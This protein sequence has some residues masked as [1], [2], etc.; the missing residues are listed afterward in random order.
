MS[1]ANVLAVSRAAKSI[2]LLGD[3]Q[4][5]EQPQKGSHPDGVGR[6]GA[7]STSS[8]APDDAAGRGIVPAGDVAAGAGICAFTSEVFYEGR[9]RRSPASS[10]SASSAPAR[11]TAP[12][13]G[14]CRWSTTAISNCVDRGSRR[15]RARWSRGC[16]R[17]ARSGSTRT[18]RARQLTA[19]RHPRRRALQRAGH[20]AG[21]AA[22]GR[23][24][25]RRH[26]GQVPGPGGAGRHL[27][28]GHVAARGRAA[29][30]GVP[31]QPQPAERGHVA[32]AVRGVHRGSP[33]SFEPE[34][35]TP[36]QMQLANALCRYREMAQLLALPT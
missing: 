7:A 4:Q 2:V 26:R 18:A 25:A 33:A 28:D 13:C 19:R 5:L 11:S 24:R 16:S 31:V 22:G 21:G 20:S 14:S 9:L 34:C 30:H 12:A 27:L 1:L 6:L 10:I 17:P 3:P 32:G 15:R 35:R 29:R 23:R 36:R 8:A